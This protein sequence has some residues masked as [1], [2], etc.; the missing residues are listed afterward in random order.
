M[1]SAGSSIIRLKGP[2]LKLSCVE[3]M[4]LSPFKGLLVLSHNAECM[5]HNL[6]PGLRFMALQRPRWHYAVNI[7]IT[8]L[9]ILQAQVQAQALALTQ[10]F[11]R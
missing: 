11:K 4:T 6:G 10:V 8:S 2:E 3:R 5:S 7:R 1:Q 9:A